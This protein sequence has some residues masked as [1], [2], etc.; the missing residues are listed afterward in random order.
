MA[1]YK[2]ES[3]VWSVR[4]ES[5]T[6]SNTSRDA[7][8]AWASAANCA[9]LSISV[10]WQFAGE[11]V[12]F[13]VY[14]STLA[15]VVPWTM[16]A[17]PAPAKRSRARPGRLTSAPRPTCPGLLATTRSTLRAPCVER[18]PAELKRTASSGALHAGHMGPDAVHRMFLHR[19]QVISRPA[20]TSELL[21]TACS[22]QPS[23]ERMV[24]AV[25]YGSCVLPRA[26][27]TALARIRCTR[28]SW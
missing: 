24:R 13:A 9:P 6:R 28:G 1:T 19:Q 11:A 2:I 16:P 22:Y 7:E 17:L 14:A 10:P 8:P 27:I 3:H 12:P 21:P 4:A 26:H 23:G 20:A 15:G 25:E 18:C 5:R